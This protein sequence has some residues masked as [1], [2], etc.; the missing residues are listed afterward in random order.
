MCSSATTDPV[1][2]PARDLAVPGRCCGAA[3]ARWA[4]LCRARFGDAALGRVRDRLS[5]VGRDLPDAPPKDAWYPVG[6]QLVLTAAILD[7]CL[8]GDA[9]ALA[10][11][12][13]EDVKAGLPRVAA[14]FLRTAGPGPVLARARQLHAH[15]YDVGRVEATTRS[16]GATVHY[17]GAALFVHPIWRLLQR[18]AFRGLVQLS[19]RE[20]VSLEEATPSDAGW[21]VDLVWR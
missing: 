13:I 10:R 17:G 21:R 18:C 2:D 5:A 19:G 8:G 20:L 11:I 6:V 15:L 16:G 3:L 12:V 4:E 7:E 14:V 9:D 1:R